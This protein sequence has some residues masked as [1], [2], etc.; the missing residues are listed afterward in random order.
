MRFKLF[1][2]LFLH[3]VLVLA[4]QPNKVVRL[5]GVAKEYA[6]YHLVLQKIINP[7]SL[8]KASIV[9]F[10]VDE[11]GEFNQTFELHKI[12]HANLDLGKYNAS[13]FLEPGKTYELVLPPFKPRTDADRFNPYY[14]PEEV[15][16][17][18][19]NEE[20]G[21][22]NQKASSFDRSLNE[23]YNANAVRIFSRGNKKLAEEIMEKL[24]SIYPAKKD[25]Y[26]QLYKQYAYGE[27]RLLAYK[28]QKNVVIHSTMKGD[29]KLQVPSFIKAFNTLYKN[30]FSN[31]FGTDQGENLRDTYSKNASFDSL[32]KVFLL[33]TIYAKREL[34]ELVLLKG[35]YDAFYS[36]RYEQE[37]IIKL[38]K[39]ASETAYTLT[40]KD[41]AKGLYKRATWLRTGTMAPQFTLYRLDGKERSLSDYKGK[42]VY[43]NFMH[44]SNHTCKKELQLLNV[45]SKQLKREL[46]IV[47]VILDEDPTKA[48]DLIK[49][50]KYKWDFL[51]FNAQPKVIL[52]YNIRAL[53]AYFVIDPKQ[54]LRLSPSPSPAENFTPIFIEAQR[55]YNYEQLRKTKTK[56]KSIYDF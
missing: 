30:F 27:L 10:K 26:F 1:F 52:D 18:I 48:K 47:T 36:G 51:H 29:L 37:Q 41:I 4:Q 31:Y 45:L 25:S 42:F 49:A 40:N 14:V 21:G 23:Q 56:E 9:T 6:G 12:T 3:S 22:L 8:E 32:V 20:S 16:L 46:T 35:L 55:K 15:V 11:K 13:I 38:L 24:D 54:I 17:G 19:A 2:F 34:A 28:R 50:N 39:Q 53:P 44:T 43:L 5:K 33:D 7:I